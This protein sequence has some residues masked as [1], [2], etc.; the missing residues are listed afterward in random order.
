MEFQSTFN[1]YF[2]MG[3]DIKQLG[4]MF[5]LFFEIYLFIYSLND[6][7]SQ[8]LFCVNSLNFLNEFPVGYFSKVSPICVGYLFI[9]VFISFSS[10]SHL[11]LCN[12]I[13]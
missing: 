2:L 4:H 3:K 5:S 12:P 9:L 1:L 13:C 7:V 6:Q 11:I 10:R 8:C